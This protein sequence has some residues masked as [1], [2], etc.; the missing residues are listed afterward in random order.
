MRAR[1]NT[2]SDVSVMPVSIYQLIFKDAD[3]MKLAPSSKLEI[4]TYR[5][6]KIKV[7]GSC[8]LLVVYL[9]T[10]C[11][12][13]VTFHVTS[14]EGSVVL[15][16]V[17]TLELCLMQPHSN[18]DSIPSSASLITSHADHPRKSKKNM[19]VSKPSKMYVQARNNLN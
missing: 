8:T 6:D 3:S 9:D 2:C 11:L 4:R 17:T 16:C 12:K 14:H 7:I 15:S 19:K 13:Q 10:Q 1:L 5:V 18:L